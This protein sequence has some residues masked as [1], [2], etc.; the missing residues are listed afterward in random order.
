M[1][2]SHWTRGQ[3]TVMVVACLI[4]FFSFVYSVTHLSGRA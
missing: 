3:W 2:E 4:T 1:D